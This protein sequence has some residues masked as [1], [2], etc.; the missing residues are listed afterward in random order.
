MA[1]DRAHDAAAEMPTA[2]SVER[3]LGQILTRIARLPD[4]AVPLLEA[5]GRALAGDVV[6]PADL[7]R[8]LRR[9]GQSGECRGAW[10]LPATASMNWP[11]GSA[12]GSRRTR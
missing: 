12:E 6:A 7:T 11:T 10:R 8:W 2:P 9:F 5:E 3:A 4:E 1:T